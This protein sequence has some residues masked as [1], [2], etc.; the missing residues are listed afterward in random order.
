MSHHIY[1]YFFPS[2]DPLSRFHPYLISVQISW[3][4]PEHPPK[5]CCSLVF[6][7]PLPL[8]FASDFH[9]VYLLPLFLFHIFLPLS[10]W[11]LKPWF[12]EKGPVLCS[13]VTFSYLLIISY[14]ISSLIPY[15]L[16]YQHTDVNS[17]QLSVTPFHLYPLCFSHFVPQLRLLHLLLCYQFHVHLVL[18]SEPNY[19]C[20]LFHFWNT[21]T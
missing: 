18:L 20:C 4:G 5:R 14:I 8:P 12:L 11:D 9:T 16:G 3:F 10:L 1:F 19:T 15:P 13:Q 21:F 17:W 7:F 6:G 2:R